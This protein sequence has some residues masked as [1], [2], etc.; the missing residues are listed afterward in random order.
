MLEKIQIFLK[1]F[2]GY[3]VAGFGIIVG[4]FLF[5]KKTDSYD[6]TI[7]DMRDS[8]RKELDDIEKERILERSRYEQNEKKYLEDLAI[9]QEKYEKAKI[10]LDEKK[11]KEIED[12]L[13]TYGNRPDELAKKL[14]EV[15]GFKIVLPE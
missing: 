13:K 10:D 9:I 11:K 6:S 12:I 2:W 3:F 4:I 7:R 8:H 1:K 5:K 14:S 15:T